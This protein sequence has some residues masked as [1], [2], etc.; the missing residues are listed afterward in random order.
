M[1]APRWSA[2][3]PSRGSLAAAL[4]EAMSINRNVRFLPGS[5][6]CEIVE[7]A[8]GPVLRLRVQA[9]QAGEPAADKPAMEFDAVRVVACIGQEIDWS[10][11][12]EIGIHPVTGGSRVRK[13]FV[14]NGL[15][16]SRQ[17]NVY[18]IGDTLNTAYLECDNFDGEPSGFREV[19]HRGNIK[20]SL[21][22]G[23]TVAEAVAQRLAGKTEVRVELDVV[24]TPDGTPPVGCRYR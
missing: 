16:E 8:K 24:G 20:A 3:L 13:T 21:I 10:L 1:P 4:D 14:L 6:A 23:V 18:V 12:K 19:K 15:L 7:T 17:P 9:P 11:F 2:S 22:D 5:E